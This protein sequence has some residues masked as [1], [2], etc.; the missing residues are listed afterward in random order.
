MGI[1]TLRGRILSFFSQ[2]VGLAIAAALEDERYPLDELIYD[3]A[4]LD[5]GFRF[6]GDEN[7]WAGRLAIACHEKYGLQSLPG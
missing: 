7:R 4:N 1:P 2:G 5:G 3:L 6:C